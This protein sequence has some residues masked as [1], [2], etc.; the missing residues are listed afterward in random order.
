MDSRDASSWRVASRSVAGS[1][2]TQPIPWSLGRLSTVSTAN[3]NGKI[4]IEDDVGRVALCQA[5]L[6]GV[7]MILVDGA[8]QGVMFGGVVGAVGPASSAR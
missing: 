1:P 3:Q 2:D 5:V 7:L 8:L 6:S 4:K